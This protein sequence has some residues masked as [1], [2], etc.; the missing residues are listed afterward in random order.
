MN[1]ESLHKPVHM[2]TC[3][4]L[5]I[6]YSLRAEEAEE[7]S[8]EFQALKLSWQITGRVRGKVIKEISGLENSWL[9]K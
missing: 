5:E 9:I 4:F 7:R 3:L 1:G 8:E 2:A 6:V